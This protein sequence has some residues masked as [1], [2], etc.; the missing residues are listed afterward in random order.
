MRISIVVPALNEE[1]NLEAAVRGLCS[2]L[3]KESFLTD[4]EILIFDDG[5]KDRTGELADKL[6]RENSRIRVI[7]NSRNMGLGYNLRKG[8]ELA[9]G[10]YVSWFP[11]DNENTPQ[12][13][14]DALKHTG[15]ADII[16][17]YTSN[18]EVRSFKRRIISTVYTFINN[19][20]FGLNVRYFNGTP[21][22]KRSLLLKVPSWSNSF[23][24]AV[25]II[26]PLLKSGAT[27]IE[28][29]VEIK[30]TSKTSALKFK[31]ILQVVKAIFS[32]F[33]RINIKRE[34]IKI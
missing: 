23:A 19:F 4:Y 33:W 11:A 24:F 18:M 21:V 9:T 34:R 26:V 25:E 1:K 20:I 10:E 22:Y 6:G 7:H 14:I 30:A 3:D 28:V 5:S 29:P 8:T 16:I 31:R 17:A 27:Y 32:L 2:F 15:E 13:L 12:S